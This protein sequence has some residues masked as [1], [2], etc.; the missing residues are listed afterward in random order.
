VLGRG[1]HYPSQ[2]TRS[3]SGAP[4]PAHA[5]AKRLLGGAP[6]RPLLRC[7]GGTPQLL[8]GGLINRTVSLQHDRIVARGTLS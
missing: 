2:S 5:P 3:R 1:R 8:S 4:E 7:P 6:V